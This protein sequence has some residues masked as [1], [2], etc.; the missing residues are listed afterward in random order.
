M[1]TT[2]RSELQA[3]ARRVLDHARNGQYGLRRVAATL[4]QVDDI[5]T[6]VLEL[7]D[8]HSTRRTT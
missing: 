7:I 4:Q 3:T 1:P 5:V 8:K 6:D 2:P